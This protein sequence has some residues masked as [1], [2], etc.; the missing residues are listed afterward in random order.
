MTGYIGAWSRGSG[1]CLLQRPLRPSSAAAGAQA[2]ADK[3]KEE[4]AKAGPS[5][6]KSA[7]ST[8]SD[9]PKA[10]LQRRPQTAVG[11]GVA[12]AALRGA[13]SRCVHQ[14]QAVQRK[15]RRPL[16]ELFDPHDQRVIHKRH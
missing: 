7:S 4:G 11:A 9:P 14:I 16:Q 13:L 8:P 12:L 6:A 2:R 5:Q 15:T 1:L 3:V 10:I